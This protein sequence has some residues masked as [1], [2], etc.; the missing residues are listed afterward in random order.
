M[1]SGRM[2]PRTSAHV[3]RLDRES[4]GIRPGIRRDGHSRVPGI[5]RSRGDG[6]RRGRRQGGNDRRRPQP[7]H[8]AGPRSAGLRHGIAWH[9]S[10]YHQCTRGGRRRRGVDRMR[11]HAI[12]PEWEHRSALCAAGGRGDREGPRSPGGNGEVPQCGDPKHGAS[13]NGRRARNPDPRRSP[14]RCRF[15]IRCCDVPGI[16]PRGFGGR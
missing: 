10:N 4:C 6:R 3:R 5:A 15:G 14:R 8:R 12:C 2:A 1:R 13:G 9:A 11:R 7:G 16:P